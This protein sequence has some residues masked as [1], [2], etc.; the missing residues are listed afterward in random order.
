MLMSDTV[1]GIFPNTFS[2]E[3]FVSVINKIKSYHDFEDDLYHVFDK[4]GGSIEYPCDMEDTLVKTLEMMFMDDTGIISDFIY[5][6]GFCLADGI[7]IEIIEKYDDGTP[8]ICNICNAEDLY[9]YLI[10]DMICKFDIERDKAKFADVRSDSTS[11][12][13][14]QHTDDFVKIYNTVYKDNKEGSGE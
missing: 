2:K 4:V 13:K 8:Y 9:D 14:E 11:N 5:D 1:R 3:K 12:S 10:R 7:Q 6:Y